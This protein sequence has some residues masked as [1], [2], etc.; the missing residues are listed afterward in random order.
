MIPQREWCGLIPSLA[1]AE[2]EPAQVDFGSR[3]GANFDRNSQGCF[4]KLMPTR[5]VLKNNRVCRRLVLSNNGARFLA[6]LDIL[7][8]LDKTATVSGVTEKAAGFLQRPL[9]FQADF[10]SQRDRRRLW[11]LWR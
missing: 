1:V 5:D 9:I 11:C 7:I 4:R 10:S 8:H 2:N 6:F 3:S